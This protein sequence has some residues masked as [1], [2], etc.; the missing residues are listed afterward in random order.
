MLVKDYEK[1]ASNCHRCGK[2]AVLDYDLSF[3]CK[4]C[5]LQMLSSVIQDLQRLEDEK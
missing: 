2:K 5:A 4:Q 3:Y 1:A